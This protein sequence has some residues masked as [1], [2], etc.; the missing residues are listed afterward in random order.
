MKSKPKPNKGSGVK[1]ICQ[2]FFAQIVHEEKGC[3][4]L[5]YS[6]YLALIEI[7]VNLFQTLVDRYMREA[8]KIRFE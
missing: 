2:C 6:G 1:T 7:G 8:E 3:L 4:K 5:V